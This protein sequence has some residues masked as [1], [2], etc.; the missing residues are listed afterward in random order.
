MRAVRNCDTNNQSKSVNRNLKIMQNFSR[1]I[2]AEE[3]LQSQ[4]RILVA[5]W[6]APGIQNLSL[7]R[8]IAASSAQLVSRWLDKEWE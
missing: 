7:A 6:M 5:S 2:R 8:V 3:I 1:R 4:S